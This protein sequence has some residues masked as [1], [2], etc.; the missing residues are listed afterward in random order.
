MK[1]QT[2]LKCKM[3]GRTI[4]QDSKVKMC[5]DCINKYG[6]P[7]AGIGIGGIVIGAKAAFKHKDK[8]AKGVVKAGKTIIS[9]IKNKS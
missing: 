3:C 8:I 9:L 7:A 1:K 4:S 5:P 6:T 2:E